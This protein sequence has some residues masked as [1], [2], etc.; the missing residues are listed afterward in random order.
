MFRSAGA[1]KN[2]EVAFSIN[3]SPRIGRSATMF[4]CTSE[5]KSAARLFHCSIRVREEKKL[6]HLAHRIAGDG[7]LARPRECLVHIRSFQYPETAHVLLGL[8]VWPI[9]DEHLTVRLL[10]HR[11]CVA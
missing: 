2:L 5:W 6:A 8:G 10:P 3:I 9:G 7:A 11:L 4:C 1:R